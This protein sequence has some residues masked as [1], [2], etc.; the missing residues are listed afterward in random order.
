MKIFTIVRNEKG[1]VLILA[2]IVMLVLT[3]IG[4]STTTNTSLELMIAGNDKVHQKTFYAAE[5]GAILGA[6]LVEQNL[7]CPSGFKKTGT[8]S[9]NDIALIGGNLEVDA[10]KLSYNTKSTNKY[11]YSK[12]TDLISNTIVNNNSADFIYPDTGSQQ[13][14]GYTFGNTS[15]QAGG[16]L[17]M[18]A[19]YERKGKSAAGGG[20]AINFSI[21]S[22]HEGQANSESI[23]KYGWRHMVG[24]ESAC[25]Y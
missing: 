1:F 10:L 9:G 22:R 19:G 12:E 24:D 11:N 4:V 23:I 20:A 8:K 6:E 3:I 17:M 25:N 7:N 21:Y 14:F 18:A 5:S 2:L 16:S 13:S 15:M